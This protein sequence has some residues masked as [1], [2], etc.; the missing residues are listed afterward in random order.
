M[1]GRRGRECYIRTQQI[2][3]LHYDTV[4]GTIILGHSGPDDYIRT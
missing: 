3:Q 1:L 2:I 4:D